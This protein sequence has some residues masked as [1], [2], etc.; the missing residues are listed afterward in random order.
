M[1]Y[2]KKLETYYTGNKPLVGQ[3]FV[4]YDDKVGKII[5]ITKDSLFP[6]VCRFFDIEEGELDVHS[7]SRDDIKKCSIDLEDIQTIVDINK[8]NI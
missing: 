4:T 5:E 8:Y 7:L 3:Y 1:K 6:Y 2:I